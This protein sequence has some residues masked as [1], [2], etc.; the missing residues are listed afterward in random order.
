[1]IPLSVASFL[2]V[3]CPAYFSH[4][5]GKNSLANGL[6]C[7]F[8]SATLVTLQ[9]DCSMKMMSR[10]QWMATIEGLAVKAL[11][12]RLSQAEAENREEM[13][14]LLWM[15]G[16]CFWACQL[17]VWSP[18]A[19]DDNKII[20]GL[21][22]VDRGFKFSLL[23]VRKLREGWSL[24]WTVSLELFHS[25]MACVMSHNTFWKTLHH[26]FVN[27]ME[28]KQNKPLTRLFSHPCAKN[29]LG[30]R[31][32]IPSLSPVLLEPSSVVMSGRKKVDT[33]NAIPN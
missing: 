1:M 21:S 14:G 26:Q 20:L 27:H 9:S 2:L 18:W 25:F 12:K 13:P 22:E 11:Y 30:T 4:T 7:F 24:R 10:L 19:L 8:P 28:H 5:E 33:R 32:Y 3:S 16:M 23:G 29:R 6:F 15:H 31:L 17:A